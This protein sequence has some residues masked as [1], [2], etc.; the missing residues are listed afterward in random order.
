MIQYGL[1]DKTKISSLFDSL[2]AG[3]SEGPP[4]ISESALELFVTVL[5]RTSGESS[6]LKESK[7]DRILTWLNAK[8]QLSSQTDRLASNRL[9][10]YA[11]P[12]LLANVLL[13]CAN[14]Q[15][16]FLLQP[17]DP[18]ETPIAHTIYK[19]SCTHDLL[20]F[21]WGSKVGGHQV[22][23]ERFKPSSRSE[24]LGSGKTYDQLIIPLV[25]QKLRHFNQ[26][27]SDSIAKRSTNA[28]R[29][30]VAVLAST[31]LT[32][33]LVAYALPNSQS[34]TQTADLAQ[35]TWFK[36]CSFL[37]S[38]GVMIVSGAKEATIHVL[39]SIDASD[40]SSR[41]ALHLALVPLLAAG[42]SFMKLP[43]GSN[44]TIDVGDEIPESTN[45][46]EAQI[47]QSSSAHARD[48]S[49][50]RKRFDTPF[51]PTFEGHLAGLW[52]SLRLRNEF[53]LSGEDFLL[54]NESTRLLTTLSD[55]DFN[56]LLLA[57][58]S[59]AIAIKSCSSIARADACRFLKR[60]AETCLQDYAWERSEAALCFCLEV[61]Q[62]LVGLWA[63][64]EDDELYEVAYDIY[65]WFLEVG[66]EKGIVTD[67]VL[68]C[69]AQLLGAVLDVNTD[70]ARG[71]S[72]PSPR[73]HLLLL[74]QKGNNVVR[75]YATPNVLELFGH[76]VLSVHDDIFDDV[77]G[78]LPIDPTYLEGIALRLHV[79]TELACKW[80]TLL[81]RSIYHLFETPGLITGSAKFA[82]ACVARICQK[83]Q[84]GDARHL[85]RLFS[86]A[87]L[88][89]WLQSQ[90][91]EAIPFHV[92]E[93]STLADLLTDV[94]QEVVAQ[95]VMREDK[96][97]LDQV[98]RCLGIAP[99]ELIEKSFSKVE[100]YCIARDISRPRSSNGSVETSVKK[101]LGAPAFSQLI[102]VHFQSIVSALVLSTDITPEFE[103]A[104]SRHQDSEAGQ[105]ASQ[106][107]RSL[108]NIPTTTAL[109]Q[110]PCF[111]MKY[112][113][114]ELAFLCK[115]AI[116][117]PKTI[118][119]PALLVYVCRDL[120]NASPSILG[121]FHACGMFRRLRL[122]L[123][124]SGP[125]ALSGYPL[126]M[127]LNT[128]Q[129]YIVDFYCSEDSIT[130]CRYL[131]TSGK[132]YLQTNPKFFAGF[133]LTSFASLLKFMDMKQD[134]TTQESQFQATMSRAQEFHSWLGKYVDT[135]KFDSKS[136]LTSFYQNLL[137]S[138]AAM[139]SGLTFSKETDEGQV[140]LMLLQNTHRGQNAVDIA[141]SDAALKTLAN[142]LKAPQSLNDDILGDDQDC[143]T[144]AQALR[145]IL[146][147]LTVPHDFRC[148]AAKA[149]GRAY[150]ASG[151]LPSPGSWKTGD[152]VRKDSLELEDASALTAL[153]TL[154]GLLLSQD[155]NQA[156]MA[157]RTLQAIVTNLN[158]LKDTAALERV[159]SRD[160][161][162]AT[163]W[164]PYMCPELPNISLP[165]VSLLSFEDRTIE[166]S[167]ESWASDLAIC[168]CLACPDHPILAFMPQLLSFNRKV[169][170]SLFPPIVHLAISSFIDAVD[171]SSRALLSRIFVNVLHFRSDATK[172]STRVVLDTLVYLRRQR[173][174]GESTTSDRDKWLDIDYHKA[175]EA[176]AAI[177]MFETALLF[178][179]IHVS[180]NSQSS[181]T[182]RSSIS[183]IGEEIRAM[184]TIFANLDD[185]DY[186]YGVPQEP[187]LE[188]VISR[189]DFESVG[190]RSLSFQSARLDAKLRVNKNDD[191]Q[192]DQGL[193]HS[194]SA[195]NLQGLAYDLSSTQG[196]LYG[197]LSSNSAQL[198]AISLRQWDFQPTDDDGECLAFDVL[199][200]A[201][202]VDSIFSIRSKLKD[203]LIKGLESVLAD[204]TYGPSHEHFADLASLSEINDLFSQGNSDGMEGISEILTG[205]T[206]W[207][208]TER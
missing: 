149:L 32:A 72:E 89:T 132:D 4:Y 99:D 137:K 60:L 169:A 115:R 177:K 10:T 96:K 13:S 34:A 120:F 139:R 92:Y 166:S 206:S 33:F 197:D 110:Q 97:S 153:R 69:T 160:I 155:T 37:S 77:I 175:A 129:P 67:R 109:S 107:I 26:M 78:S 142:V 17:T 181:R 154:S 150:S 136:D 106:V 56:D 191:R 148:W 151:R 100:A 126:Q 105:S 101:Q 184:H 64:G 131:L 75:F 111:K 31:C 163:A 18:L 108:G 135:F 85:F 144:Y 11:Q 145:E 36:V 30:L 168:L 2:Y 125:T 134:S 80:Q 199:Q 68:I 117:D 164:S 41:Q 178:F 196:K 162:D 152:E 45:L 190:F 174:P 25:Q 193:L 165:M 205:R 54:Q 114:D 188:S 88:Y 198:M 1:A 82:K 180:R 29:D 9:A 46:D 203:S 143:V 128:V 187:T 200:C 43:S 170:E 70:F 183:N 21:L 20:Q 195:A 130:I 158:G 5:H 90:T 51:S 186:F 14:H 39:S 40:P 104:F 156:G 38:Q 24:R 83:L 207:M 22:K 61:M 65:G 95:S 6:T 7:R 119:T 98:S 73:T 161:L 118:W 201:N 146:K 35:G 52:L 62:A 84:I 122:V 55:V 58:N 185:P 59:V 141:A 176:A 42:E 173:L 3:G 202:R 74:L 94:L 44:G 172:T 189:L 133:A 49:A 157:E 27:W 76:F 81:R 50:G 182:R 204:D 48:D 93:Y 208:Y 57:R 12:A 159:L 179:E 91:V 194:L 86:P 127:L 123:A 124:M 79:L 112:I 116:L 167:T 113:L 140:F 47:S 121:P 23:V 8:W 87:I 103:K 28:T 63:T 53:R 192:E 147:R 15:A 138:S 16:G 19:K 102:H 171:T 71:D 66:L